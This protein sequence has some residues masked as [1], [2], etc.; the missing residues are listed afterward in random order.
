MQSGLNAAGSGTF[1]QAPRI[2]SESLAKS[3]KRRATTACSWCQFR[4]IRCNVEESNPCSNCS[5]EKIECTITK[6]RRTK[7]DKTSDIDVTLQSEHIPALPFT[8]RPLDRETLEL[9]DTALQNPQQIVLDNGPPVQNPITQPN[10]QAPSTNNV[11]KLLSCEACVSG[12]LLQANDIKDS[13]QDSAFSSSP[14][15]HSGR[16]P[17][18]T[19]DCASKRASFTKPILPEY[20]EPIPDH[21]SPDDLEYLQRKGSFDIPSEKFRNALICSYGEWS[22]PYYPMFQI[23]EFL[24]DIAKPT[25][26]TNKLSLLVFQAVLFAGSAHCDIKPLRAMGFMTRKAARRALFERTKALYHFGYEQNR[27]SVIQALILMSLWYSTPDDQMDAYHWLNIAISLARRASLNRDPAS[28]A[29]SEREKR[30]RKRI[31][32]CCLIRDPLLALGLKRPIIV[33]PDDHDVPELKL[34]DFEIEDLEKSHEGLETLGQSWNVKRIRILRQTCISE[35]KLHR[36]LSQI[37]S[38]QYALGNHHRDNRPVDQKATRA[39]LLPLTTDAAWR[40]LS[41]CE[42]NLRIWRETLPQEVTLT[43]LSPES[44]DTEFDVCNVFRIVVHMVYHTCIITM[45]RPWLRPVRAMSDS[46]PGPIDPVFQSKIQTAIRASAQSITD[47]AVELHK[48][49]L[50]RHLPQTGLSAMVAAAVSHISDIASGD[51]SVQ[52]SA[53]QGFE[54]CS[55]MLNELRENYYSADFSSE[56]VN[57]LARA[58]PPAQELKSQVIQNSLSHSYEFDDQAIAQKRFLGA[59]ETPAALPTP[60][61]AITVPPAALFPNDTELAIDLAMNDQD[62]SHLDFTH[63]E[64]SLGTQGQQI[65]AA[66]VTPGWEYYQNFREE[67]TR[68]LPEFFDD[69]HFSLF[70]SLPGIDLGS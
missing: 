6:R 57:L 58:K 4:K 43:T 27:I 13:L 69:Y 36:C 10:T 12:S 29:I 26:S 14:S 59:D 46:L 7:K 28:M 31:W 48:A 55:H 30:M 15:I 41:E 67:S 44:P 64:L 39:I 53:Q 62:P 47:F 54:K 21:L 3:F 60:S 68:L 51:E 50:A 66:E 23:D 17:S 38:K 42:D 5:I 22:H 70:N 52:G 65:M 19:N 63:A 61:V 11:D 20:L 35:A 49:D 25:E 16:S 45:Y 40:S 56:F 34:D 37:M 32:W 33:S 2:F 1:S 9:P 18:T 8:A 24:A